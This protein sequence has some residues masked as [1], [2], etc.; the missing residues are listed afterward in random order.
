MTDFDAKA[1]DHKVS[2]NDEK[3]RAETDSS[4]EAILASEEAGHHDLPELT[5][6]SF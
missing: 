4:H 5:Q 3:E 2:S 1:A 6:E